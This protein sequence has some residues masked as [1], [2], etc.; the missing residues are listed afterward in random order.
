MTHE[1]HVVPQVYLKQFAMKKMCYVIDGYGK[2]QRKS[3]EGICY[4]ADYYELRSADGKIVRTNWIEND[5]LGKVETMYSDY[6]DDLCNA[7]ELNDVQNFMKYEDNGLCLVT[8][9]VIMLLRSLL[10]FK[11]TPEVAAEL[12]IEWNDIQSHNNAIFNISALSE[13][14]SR[15]IYDTH[16]IVFI[17]N[18]TDI[19]F[20][21]GNYPSIIMNDSHGELHG[22]MPLSPKYYVFLVDRDNDIEEYS[23]NQAKESDVELYNRNMIRNVLKIETDVKH[24]YIISRDKESLE[25]YTGFVKK[26]LAK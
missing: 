14:F 23:I 1:E 12:G 2:I 20:L 9:M 4:E 10:V 19:S 15:K 21:T 5:L 3:I 26:V 18:D 13:H 6:L 8:W 16:K 24:K 7:L 11:L 25:H 17:K 22:Y